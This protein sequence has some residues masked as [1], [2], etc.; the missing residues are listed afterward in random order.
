MV[1]EVFGTPGCIWWSPTSQHLAFI[2]ITEDSVPVYQIPYYISGNSKP[3]PYPN[4]KYLKY[5]KPGF[6]NPVVDVYVYSAGETW[7]VDVEA[8]GEGW[9]PE[10]L[11]TNVAWLGD[12]Y[13][14][15]SET[16]RISTHF[17]GVLVNI[18]SKGGEITR[19]E[20]ISEGWFEIVL[21][22]PKKS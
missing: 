2:H 15:L 8:E 19:D 21:L 13:L 10:K 6:P 12:D 16:N 17:R 14:Y 3:L 11:I 4:F 22:F 20:V 9:G 18:H 1:E 7:R 5:P